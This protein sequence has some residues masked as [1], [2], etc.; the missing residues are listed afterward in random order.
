MADLNELIPELSEWNEGQGISAELWINGLG[1]FE[2]A[3]AYGCLFWPEFIEHD[4]C[5]FR[6]AGFEK[7]NY[8]SWLWQTCRNKTATEKVM[9]HV[10]IADLFP[11]APRPTKQ[12]MIYFG[13]LLRELWA[14]KLRR[15]FP[16]RSITVY[17][18][19]EDSDECYDYEITFY[20]ER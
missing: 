18:F 5:V 1:S 8:R 2:H 9:N 16:D 17:F 13:R 6:A 4:G 19:D 12:Q 3:I 14:C 11:N 10:H 20:Q 15:D 7:K